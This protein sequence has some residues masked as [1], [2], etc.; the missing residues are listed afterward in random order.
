[1]EV[2]RSGFYEHLGR[3][4]SNAR[5]E[6]GALEGFVVEAFERRKGRC[7]CRRI[8]RELRKSGIAV[9]EKRVLR[10]MRKPGFAGRG[11]TRKHRIQ[12]K[13]EPGDPRLNLASGGRHRMHARERRAALS[14]RRDRRLLPQGRGLVDVRAHHR[15]GRDR[16]DRA[17]GWQG[18]PAG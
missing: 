16:R 8:D 2:S 1:M 4:K 9:S 14:R 15:E 18:G 7:G 17:G 5:I 12:K 10:I 11:A 3:K 13:A 6:R